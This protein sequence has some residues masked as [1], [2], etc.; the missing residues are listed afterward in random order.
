MMSDFDPQAAAEAQSQPGTFSFVERLQG[1][2]YPHS[3]VKVYL[4]EA[5][6]FERNELALR[7]GTAESIEQA[8]QI[9]EKIEELDRKLAQSRY[10]FELHGFSPERYDEVIDE[11]FEQFPAEYE[12][13]INPFSGA[14][15]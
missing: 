10:L 12:T 5:T 9:E 2:G 1:R 11:A 15:S 14:S 7:A 4:D 13:S 6:A 3:T 8:K